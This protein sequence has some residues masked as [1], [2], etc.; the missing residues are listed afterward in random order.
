MEVYWLHGIDIRGYQRHGS[1]TGGGA[2]VEALQ[3]PCMIQ[4]IFPLLRVKL[5]DSWDHWD[6]VPNNNTMCHNTALLLLGQLGQLG[7]G[8]QLLMGSATWTQVIWRWGH[9][10][11]W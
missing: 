3:I 10:S 4:P 8:S 9:C 1:W 7:Q 6:R 11:Y 2:R 5:R